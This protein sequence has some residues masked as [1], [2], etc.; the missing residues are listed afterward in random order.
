MQMVKKENFIIFL[1]IVYSIFCAF[2]ISES[3][4]TSYYYNVGKDRLDYLFSL[5]SNKVDFQTGSSQFNPGVYD[6]IS[7]FFVQ[8]FPVKFKFQA[9]FLA[10]LI[11]STLTIFGIYNLCK[12]IFNKIV[13]KI[14]FIYLFF[15]P[16]FFGHMSMNSKDT[17]IAFSTVWFIYF[18]IRYLQKQNDEE[19]R[20]KYTYLSAICLA[21]G[22]GARTSF[23]VTIIP[24]IALLP[25]EI[26]YFKIFIKKNFLLKKFLFDILKVI[27]ISYLI[28]ILFW[29]QTHPN[30]FFLPFKLTLESLSYGYGVPLTL[31]DGELLLS[32]EL[33]KTYIAKNLFYKMPEYI[34]LSYLFFFL[35]FVKIKL[36]FKKQFKG[37][38]LKIFFILSIIITPNILMIVSPFYP[39]DGM[40]LFLY[41]IPFICIPPAVL[42]YF[43]YKKIKTKFYLPFFSIILFFKIFLIGNFLLLTPFNYVYLNIFAGKYS[44]NYK[45]FENDYSG[46]TVKELIGKFKN[47]KFSTKE[48]VLISICGLPKG[49]VNRHL[50]QLK[51]INYKIVNNKESYDYIIMNNRAV[52]ED[53]MSNNKRSC[54]EKFKGKDVVTVSRRGLVLSKITKKKPT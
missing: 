27:L 19:K 14:A 29:P 16:V 42:T 20:K 45:K 13:G 21:L 17:I 28:I 36:F 48:T 25:L 35:F 38:T 49:S 7:A 46:I 12:I 26:L 44:E 18:T 22:M 4:D 43:L 51:N 11:V 53:Y 10:N 33:P 54:F 47:N 52:W 37:F 39:Y 32:T 41:L 6:T 9:I 15:N 23:I 3:W 2:N 24:M 1:L 40:R 5:G 31:F 30:I 8:L 50:K 34:L